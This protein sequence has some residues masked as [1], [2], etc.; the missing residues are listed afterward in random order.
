[1]SG[2]HRWRTTLRP[3]LG[4]RARSTAAAILVVA[5]GLAVGA[6]LLLVLL[7]Q[8]LVASAG[9]AAA[10]RA[11]RGRRPGPVRCRVGPRGLPRGDEPRCAARAARRTGGRGARELGLP[12]VGNAGVG[13]ASCGR[14]GGP[15]GGRLVADSPR[16]RPLPARRARPGLART[17]Q[18][19]TVLVA[20]VAGDGG[21]DGRHR[22]EVRPRGAASPAAARPAGL[23]TWVLVGRALRPVERIRARV[24]GHRRL[25]GSTS[26]SPCRRHGDEI[27]R[28]A[29]DDERDA[30][31]PRGRPARASAGSSPT[32]ATSCAARSPRSPPSLEVA[33][34]GPRRRG[35]ARAARRS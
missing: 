15:G 35:L 30:R 19:R 26:G 33:G 31:P 11:S 9:E 23:A 25:A 34:A 12:R 3:L 13:A 20:V 4:I 17:G 22:S 14:A 1:M 2:L 7:R 24:A 18:P 32:P 10:A 29:V 28:L 8:S 16:W 27:A 5:I 21:R 6:T